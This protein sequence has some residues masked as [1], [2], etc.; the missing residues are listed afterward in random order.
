[1]RWPSKTSERRDQS[2]ADSG[3]IHQRPLILG[4]RCR[5]IAELSCWASK[6]PVSFCAVHISPEPKQPLNIHP[7]PNDAPPVPFHFKKPRDTDR[8]S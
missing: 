8:L 6:L 1:M 3:F 4:L 2:T 7:N 5:S